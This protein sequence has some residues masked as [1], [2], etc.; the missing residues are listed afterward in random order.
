MN[1]VL[2]PFID[3]F[4]VVYFDDIL[5]FSRSLDDHADHLRQVL[6]TLRFESFFVNLKK[7]SFAPN[8]VIFLGFIVSSQGVTAN[9]EKVCAIMDWPTPNNI[10]E[11]CS[12]HGLASFYRRF[13]WGLSSVMAPSLNA[14]R[15]A[16]SF[17][18]L[19]PSKPSRPTRNSLQK[20]QCYGYPILKPPPKYLVM[21][22]ILALAAFSVKVDIPSLILVRS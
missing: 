20:H 16:L 14:P 17:G 3:K 21:P 4:V 18:P 19:L 10:H 6:Q 13:L 5:I 11:V 9:P 12:F 2:K 15:R 22:Y 1:Q 7:C 8:N